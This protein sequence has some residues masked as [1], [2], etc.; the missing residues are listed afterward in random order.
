[1]RD[2]L[3]LTF[4]HDDR[5]CDIGL[6]AQADVDVAHATLACVHGCCICE[7][8]CWSAVFPAHHLHLPER[9]AARGSG[10]QRLEESLLRRE[11]ACK[12]PGAISPR[13]AVG[14]F[15]LGPQPLLKPAAVSLERA[16]YTSGVHHVE[17]DT[18]NHLASSPRI[19]DGGSC[20]GSRWPTPAARVA[21]GSLC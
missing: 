2:P 13:G 5:G 8:Q 19:Q 4:E 9:E 6:V 11:P 15:G 3:A 21:T 18:E 7:P 12:R 1:M 10:A 14:Q 17:P 16:S 20:P